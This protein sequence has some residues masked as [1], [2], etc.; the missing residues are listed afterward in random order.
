MSTTIPGD[1][2]TL[3]LA[4]L[5]ATRTG[6]SRADILARIPFVFS[7]GVEGVL[8]PHVA[9]S[10]APSHLLRR[11]RQALPRALRSERQSADPS[12]RTEYRCRSTDRTDGGHRACGDAGGNDRRSESGAFR[13]GEG[14]LPYGWITT[15]KS[16]GRRI[17]ATSPANSMA[18]SRAAAAFGVG[19]ALDELPAPHFS[20]AALLSDFDVFSSV[21]STSSGIEIKGLEVVV[22]V[23]RA[24]GRATTSSRI[25]RSPMR[26]I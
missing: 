8:T 25:S 17:K 1:L 4:D 2:L 3:T 12:S 22:L 18:Y 6:R 26:W 23:F 19:R 7:G 5:L 10:S 11:R 21:A 14:A 15:A 24:P 13:P 20:E 16:S 9:L